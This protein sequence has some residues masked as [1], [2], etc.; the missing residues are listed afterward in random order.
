[1][2][3]QKES[4]LHL[5]VC[6]Y[7]KQ[8]YPDVIF[9]SE[10]SGLRVSIHQ[11]KILKRLRSG[12]GLP[13][14]IILQPK[15]EYKGLCLELKTVKATPYLK[16]GKLSKRTHIQKQA[17]VLQRLL[18]LGYYADFTVGFKDTVWKIDNYMNIT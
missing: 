14:I 5:A 4:Q 12:D 13:D 18:K 9:T 3:Y 15:G 11:A 10:S 17:E 6:Q 1:M 8:T 16:S 7:I 2:E